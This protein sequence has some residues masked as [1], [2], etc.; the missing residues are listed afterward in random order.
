M[1]SASATILSPPPGGTR[2]G[3]ALSSARDP[4]APLSP[5][6]AESR[7]YCSPVDEARDTLGR[8][9]PTCTR[10]TAPIAAR[11]V[12]GRPREPRAVVVDRIR[13]EMGFSPLTRRSPPSPPCFYGLQ[14]VDGAVQAASRRTTPISWVVGYS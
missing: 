6:R 12:G 2:S 13:D 10:L 8:A 3:F 9:R 1:A 4:W 5:G 7:R 11:D 14:A